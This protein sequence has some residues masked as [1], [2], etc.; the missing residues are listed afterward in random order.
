MENGVRATDMS[1][2]AEMAK[3]GPSVTVGGLTVYGID[4]PTIVLLLT[5]IYTILQIVFLLRDKLGQRRR[6]NYGGERE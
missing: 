5:A 2:T 3:A 1:I 6:K 4:L